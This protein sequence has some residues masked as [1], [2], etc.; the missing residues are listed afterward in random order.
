MTPAAI[1]GRGAHV[2]VR[3]LMRPGVVSVLESAS[4]RHAARTMLSH[5]IHALLVTRCGGAA[6]G[7]VTADEL[8]AWLGGRDDLVPVGRVVARPPVW[9]APSLTVAEALRAMVEQD[10]AHLVVGRAPDDP[11]GV[12]SAFDLLGAALPRG[13]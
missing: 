10:A 8:L 11:Q 7:W 5:G 9:V 13:G 2:E 4:I 1:A 3:A 6:L 12:L